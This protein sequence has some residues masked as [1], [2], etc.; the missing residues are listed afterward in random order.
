M[1]EEILVGNVMGHDSELGYFLTVYDHRPETIEFM[2]QN[3]LQGGG[4]TWMGLIIA[5]MKAESPNT[6]TSL[7][8][9]DSSDEVLV[10]SSSKATLTLVQ[11]YVSILMTDSDFMGNCITNARRDG[12][13]E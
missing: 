4:P 3:M 11:N 2:R 7:E 5:A 6:L 8:F 10:S 9:D 13:M 12:Y 1:S